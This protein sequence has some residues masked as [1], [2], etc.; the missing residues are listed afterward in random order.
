MRDIAC[1]TP[2]DTVDDLARARVRKTVRRDHPVGDERDANRAQ[3]HGE[4]RQRGE[5]AVLE[6]DLI[7]QYTK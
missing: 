7:D 1:R 3:P 6:K 5:E 2:T 4:V